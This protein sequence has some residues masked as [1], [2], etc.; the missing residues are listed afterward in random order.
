M[1]ITATKDHCK[2][3]VVLL[4]IKTHLLKVIPPNQLVKTKGRKFLL[5]IGIQ[6]RF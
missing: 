4:L 3:K 5:E 2:V 1:L 6:V